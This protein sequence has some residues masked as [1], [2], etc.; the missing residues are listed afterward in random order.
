MIL[1]ALELSI[2]TKQSLLKIDIGA[3]VVDV[4]KFVRDGAESKIWRWFTP[5]WEAVVIKQKT[6]AC[7]LSV[8]FYSSERGEVKSTGRGFWFF[9]QMNRL[10]LLLIHAPSAER[11]NACGYGLKLFP[12][13]IST[14]DQ[15]GTRTRQI[16][17]YENISDVFSR[18]TVLN[19]E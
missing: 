4:C 1:R 12:E 18:L 7:A 2:I 15:S 9:L 8:S 11:N 17:Q 16:P 13:G 5:S 10:G 6:M 3:E 14:V 19:T